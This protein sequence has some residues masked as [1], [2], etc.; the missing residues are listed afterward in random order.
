MPKSTLSSNINRPESKPS[1]L[2]F[3]TSSVGNILVTLLLAVCLMSEIE[4]ALD[5]HIGLAFTLLSS[6]FTP[7]HN[8]SPHLQ[9]QLLPKIC[10]MM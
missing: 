10:G 8:V 4:H 9:H 7:R 6:S 2:C 5:W 3:L 1:F